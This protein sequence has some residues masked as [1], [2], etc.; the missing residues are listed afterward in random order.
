MEKSKKSLSKQQ[1]K[2]DCRPRGRLAMIESTLSDLQLIQSGLEDDIDQ[3]K[4]KLASILTNE[5]TNNRMNRETSSE[6]CNEV[7]E[8]C[9]LL[10]KRI[11]ELGESTAKACKSLGAGIADLQQSSLGF[12]GWADRARS[13]IGVVAA[14]AGLPS[15]PC[16]ALTL[17]GGGGG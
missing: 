16:P 10:K 15:N 1:S 11:R 5:T 3:M 17:Q 6:D 8:E 14:A 12:Y 9:K 4:S 13:S 2:K 7:K